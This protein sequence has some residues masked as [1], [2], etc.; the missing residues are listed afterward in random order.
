M[1]WLEA[2]VGV[3]TGDWLSTEVRLWLGWVLVGVMGEMWGFVGVVLI[4]PRFAAWVEFLVEEAAAGAFVGVTAVWVWGCSLVLAAVVC[5]ATGIWIL[6]WMAAGMGVLLEKVVWVWLGTGVGFTGP[7]T[8]CVLYPEC[9][10]SGSAPFGE[11]PVRL[12]RCRPNSGDTLSVEMCCLDLRFSGGL[13]HGLLLGLGAASHPWSPLGVDLELLGDVG[14]SAPPDFSGVAPCL[15]GGGIPS[16]L[17][18]PLPGA[19]L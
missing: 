4:V 5:F 12:T 13:G 16:D 8:G 3:L 6:V 7:G 17:L 10:S 9:S 15:G 2:F 18:L 14:F 19:C 11:L 1:V